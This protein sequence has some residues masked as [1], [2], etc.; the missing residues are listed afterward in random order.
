ML[1]S[2]QWIVVPGGPGLSNIYLKYALDKMP[3]SYKLNFYHMYGAPES[4]NKSPSIDNM[5]DQISQ[6]ADERDLSEY[7]LIPHS[8]GNYIALRGLQK[9]NGSIRA[10]IMLNP[11]PFEFHAWKSVLTRIEEKI[12]KPVLEELTSLSTSDDLSTGMKLFR[13]LFP[14]YIDNKQANLPVDVPFDAVVCHA[15]ENK[16]QEYD[17][18]NLVASS[19][20]PIVRIVGE[21]DLF[22]D[23]REILLKKTIILPNVGHYPFFEDQ[24][25]FYKAMKDAGEMLCRQTTTRRK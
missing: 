17:D 5:I 3:I 22:F 6:V 19:A 4:N 12:P 23:D 9:N 10:I 11:M 21:K 8:F 13:L 14:Y 25:N 18:R 1:D 7:G 15:I 20:I 2:L 16:I 24:N